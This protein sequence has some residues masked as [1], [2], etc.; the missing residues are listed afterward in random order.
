VADALDRA[1]DGRAPRPMAWW[2]WGSPE[3]DRHLPEHALNFLREQLGITGD[4]RPVAAL[5]DVRVP[6]PGL[7]D[8]AAAKLGAV[9]TDHAARVEHAAGKGYPD[10]VRLRAGDGSGAPDAVLEP[11]SEEEVRGALQ[12]CAEADLAVVPFGGGTS[13]VGGVEPLRGEHAGVVALDLGAVPPLAGQAEMLDQR[14][15]RERDA[16]ELPDVQRAEEREA[17]RG[18]P[19]GAEEHTDSEGHEERRH[20]SITVPWLIV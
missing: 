3:A 17:A 16:P 4:A 2:G 9:R 6:A 5:E 15:H 12:A 13:V 8:D 18:E 1:R 11:G 19:L 7:S 14:Q 10:L 20:Q